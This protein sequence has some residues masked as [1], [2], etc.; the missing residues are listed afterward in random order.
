MI[1]IIASLTK[2]LYAWS[3]EQGKSP[4]H[5]CIIINLYHILNT[6]FYICY[7]LPFSKTSRLKYKVFFKMMLYIFY[8][9]DNEIILILKFEYFNL[10]H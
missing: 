1:T 6:T 8:R 4:P 5:P 3:Q 9:T 2:V 7:L 10:Y